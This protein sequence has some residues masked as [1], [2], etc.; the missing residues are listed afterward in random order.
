MTEKEIFNGI[1]KAKNVKNN[2]LYFEREIEDIESYVDSNP[3]LT[4]KF[5]DLD[6]DKK[7]DKL[8]NNLLE[9]LKNDKIRSKLPESNI[10]KFKVIFYQFY[11]D[12]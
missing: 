4:A 1:L 2:V 10:F 12:I 5:I 9:V 7:I 11:F 6:S 8:A 3:S